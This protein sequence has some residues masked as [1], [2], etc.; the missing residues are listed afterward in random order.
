MNKT[1]LNGA[2]GWQ[3]NK[4]GEFLDSAIEKCKVQAAINQEATGYA[5]VTDAKENDEGVYVG[6]HIVDNP[7]KNSH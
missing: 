7:L 6:K 5:L 4:V 3:Q 2:N 1:V